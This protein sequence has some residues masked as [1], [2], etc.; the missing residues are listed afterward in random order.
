MP[1]FYALALIG[2]KVRIPLW[3]LL[4]AAG[5]VVVGVLIDRWRKRRASRSGA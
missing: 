4:A 1:Y 5:A 3:V 2:S